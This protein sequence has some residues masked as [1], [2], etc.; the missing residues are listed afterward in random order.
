MNKKIVIIGGGGHA[1][2][3]VDMLYRL[4]M[5]VFSFISPQP[6]LNAI[7]FSGITQWFSDDILET[8][9]PAEYVLV[10][11]I[12]SVPGSKLREKIALK[13]RTLGFEFMTLISPDAYVSPFANL[14]EGVQVMPKAV[15][16]PGCEIGRDVIINTGSIVE[17]DCKLGTLCH[18]APGAVLS[19]AVSIGQHTHIG[20]GAAVIQGIV[21]GQDSLIGA[22]SVIN[23]NISPNTIVYPAKPFIRSL[24]NVK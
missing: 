17:H 6:P 10:N 18:L 4:K 16:Q 2:V 9:C 7:I 3:L 14:S 24:N 21:I 11:G 5:P 8:L 23:K 12:G 19:G 13:G 20:T 15:I 22:G 1:S